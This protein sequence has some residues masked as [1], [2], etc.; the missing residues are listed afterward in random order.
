MNC[1]RIAVC[2]LLFVLTVPFLDEV[3]VNGSH[4]F[5]CDTKQSS[6]R[7]SHPQ[8]LSSGDHAA[9]SQECADP[10]HGGFSHFGHSFFTPAKGISIA[11]LDL[12]VRLIIVDYQF[13]D[14]PILEAPRRPPRF[15]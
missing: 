8:T 10:C 6:V 4:F 7:D 3:L 2:L 14:G 11:A 5:D 15:A 13:V 1:F 12:Y 9:H